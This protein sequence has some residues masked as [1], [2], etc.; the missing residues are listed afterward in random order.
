MAIQSLFAMREQ[1]QK[2][3]EDCA[4]I[5]DLNPNSKKI[6]GKALMCKAQALSKL[7]R[8]EEALTIAKQWTQTE[9]K[10]FQ[11][12]KEY[13]RLK[14]LVEDN[15]D[16]LTNLDSA[17]SSAIISN[18]SSAGSKVEHPASTVSPKAS[19]RTPGEPSSS[20]SRARRL[21]GGRGL[22]PDDHRKS[23]NSRWYCSYCNVQCSSTTSLQMHCLSESHQSII[24][25]D[26][27]RDWKHRPPPRG[28]TSDDYILCPELQKCRFGERCTSAHSEEELGEWKE[29][30]RYRLMKWQKAKDRQLHGS[31]FAEQVLEKWLGSTN[32]TNVMVESI[33]EV[34]VTVNSELNISISSKNSAHCWTFTLQCARASRTYPTSARSGPSHPTQPSD[35]DQRPCVPSQTSVYLSDIWY[36]P[37]VHCIR[38]RRRALRHETSQRRFRVGSDK[39]KLEEAREKFFSVGDRWD[40]TMKKVVEFSPKPAFGMEEDEELRCKYRPPRSKEELIPQSVLEKYLMKNNY[41]T[42]M[43]ELLYIEEL[44]QFKEMSKYNVRTSLHIISSFLLVPSRGAGARYAQGGELFALLKLNNQL[45][46]DTMGGRLILNNCNSALLATVKDDRLDSIVYEAL[47]E[48]KSKDAIYFRFSKLCV[49]ELGLKADDMV[50]V[51][52]QFQLNRLPLCEWHYA[53]DQVADL[54]LLFPNVRIMPSI[55]W[56]PTKYTPEGFLL[57]SFR[58]WIDK[59]DPRIN[60]KQKEAVMAISTPLEIS[61][62]PVFL[63]GPYGTGKTFTLAHATKFILQ[64]KDTRILICTHSNSAAD[65]Y[66]RDYFH[67][68]VEAGNTAARPLRIYFKNRWTQTVHPVVRLY[69][70][71]SENEDRFTMPSKEEVEKYR[72]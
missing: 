5:L 68:Y 63:V 24:T 66:I 42:R 45:S 64:Q 47:I 23:R 21:H 58:Q 56:T 18:G 60:S 55:P 51:E 1:F 40:N 43:H 29:R 37:S 39:Q 15:K 22:S 17:K 44:T 38:F 52:L 54:E 30:Y 53:V 67:A 19:K 20:H 50:E 32:P 49:E 25:S 59:L 12:I 70:H 48:E 10:N 7:N 16:V 3:S 13:Q 34:K 2:A 14:Q 33:D 4:R 61:L 41:K 46:S 57:I 72:V 28:V 8:N 65:L 11:A 35:Q 69:C 26:K 31:S 9:P 71:M 27:G 6:I 36:L 62:P